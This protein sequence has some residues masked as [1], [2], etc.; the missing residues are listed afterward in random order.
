M[1][2]TVAAAGTGLEIGRTVRVRLPYAFEPYYPAYPSI[3]ALTS[4]PSRPA[5]EFYP[6]RPTFPEY[7]SVPTFAAYP[8]TGADAPEFLSA[9]S[10]AGPT[11]P[12]DAPP[13]RPG[14]R[15]ALLDLNSAGPDRRRA[16]CLGLSR[17]PD[18][19]AIAPLL[20]LAA[21]DTDYAM[22]GLAV[23]GPRCLPGLARLEANPATPAPVRHRLRLVQEWISTGSDAAVTVP[24]VPHVRRSGGMPLIHRNRLRVMTV[25]AM[26]PVL[27]LGGALCLI[28]FQWRKDRLDGALI[29]AIKRQDAGLTATLL[30]SGADANAEDR[31]GGPESPWEIAIALFR[32]DLRSPCERHGPSALLVAACCTTNA[33]GVDGDPLR[34]QGTYEIVRSLLDHGAQVNFTDPGGLTPLLGALGADRPRTAILLIGR[35]ADVCARRSDSVGDGSGVWECG[36]KSMHDTPELLRAV[37]LHQANVNAVVRIDVGFGTPIMA[38]ME[39]QGD[40]NS[41]VANVRILLEAGADP[42]PVVDYEVGTPLAFAAR[43]AGPKVGQLLL[44]HG[45]KI[46]LA[47]P[48]CGTPLH[49]ANEQLNLEITGIQRDGHDAQLAAR[50][51][52]Y[53]E[54]LKRRGAV[55]RT[56][57][58]DA[59]EPKVLGG[60]PAAPYL[61]RIGLPIGKSAGEA[62]KAGG[63]SRVRS[64]AD[65]RRG[66][67]GRRRCDEAAAAR[68]RPSANHRCQARY[69]G[70]IGAPAGRRKRKYHRQ[71]GNPPVPARGIDYDDS[72]WR[73]P[74]A[75]RDGLSVRFTD[76]VRLRRVCKRPRCVPL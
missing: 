6:S 28:G 49:W 3:P 62:N 36:Y 31:S 75:I 21:H 25:V 24:D 68:P 41:A 22:F 23:I 12:S 7:P 53:I 70:S 72:R 38:M 19:A 30:A 66:Y 67:D 20:A 40:T 26:M 27:A 46:N 8:T 74:S 48:N 2:G 71:P 39:G 65:R 73:R 10:A 44:E 14:G 42:N 50:L 15:L 56:L 60:A 16:A 45:A 55:D 54:F 51:R 61:H 29:A 9:S 11:A 58:N 63:R 47:T 13:G 33:A 37:I 5:S 32:P 4:Y 35:G 18:R 1:R 64:N 17:T 52:A 59:A 57:P 69:S 34:E 76:R 43:N